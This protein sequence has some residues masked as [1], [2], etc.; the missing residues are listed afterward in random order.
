V[1]NY[2]SLF[3]YFRPLPCNQDTPIVQMTPIA[4]HA[5]KVIL[6]GELDLRTTEFL[7]L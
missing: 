6:A 2:T 7:L 3:P 5:H 4:E 1:S